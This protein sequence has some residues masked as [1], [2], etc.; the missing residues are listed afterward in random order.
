MQYKIRLLS[1]NLYISLQVPS[2]FQH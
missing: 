2:P 1:T